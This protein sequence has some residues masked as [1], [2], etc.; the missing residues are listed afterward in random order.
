MR[1]SHWDSLEKALTVFQLPGNPHRRVDLIFA[2]PEV[3]WTAVL[4]WYVNFIVLDNV[5]CSRT[6]VS[7]RTGSKMFERD[8]RL[9]AKQEKLVT[10]I[11]KPLK[12]LT[13]S[14]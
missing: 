9:Y 3:Y 6:C 11:T 2:A 13:K 7:D 5:Y 12:H 8:L 1:T 14:S 10:M 4:G